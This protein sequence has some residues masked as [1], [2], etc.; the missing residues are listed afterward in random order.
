MFKHISGHL[1]AKSED[2]MG[3]LQ[4]TWFWGRPFCI[5]LHHFPNPAGGGRIA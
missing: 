2:N 5:I 4:S 1:Y 3:E